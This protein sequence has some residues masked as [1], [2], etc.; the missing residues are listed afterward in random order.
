[1]F[2][3]GNC[4]GAANASEVLDLPTDSVPLRA[5]STRHCSVIF[6]EGSLKFY[7][8]PQ[9]WIDGV[10]FRKDH[11]KPVGRFEQPVL[12]VGGGSSLWMTDVVIQGSGRGNFECEACALR[13]YGSVFA[14][15][16]GPTASS[17][18]V[19]NFRSSVQGMGPVMLL[20]CIVGELPF[21][22]HLSV[23]L[24]R[25]TRHFCV[26]IRTVAAVI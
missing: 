6:E 12:E 17:N 9:V 11:S 18:C 22:L 15:G 4:A 20:V 13:I 26:L 8:S 24:H 14:A 23:N 19:S 5:V 3:Q 16:V 7:A 2:M 21:N 10:Y 1:M 25:C